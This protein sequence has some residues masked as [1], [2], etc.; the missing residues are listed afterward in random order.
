MCEFERQYC[1]LLGQLV[2]V[3]S[4]DVLGLILIELL[5]LESDGVVLAI[6]VGVLPEHALCIC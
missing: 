1:R 5:P 3:S 4:V 6:G 2:L